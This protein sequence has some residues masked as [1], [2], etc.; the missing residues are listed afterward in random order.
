VDDYPPRP[1]DDLWPDGSERLP[2]PDWKRFRVIWETRLPNLRIRNSCED[3]CPECFILK[4]KFKYLGSRRRGDNEQD[5]PPVGTTEPPVDTTFINDDEQL[6]FNA[7]QH[8]EQAKQQRDIAYQ[9][10]QE[11]FDE[12][13]NEHKEQRFVVI[14][15]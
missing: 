15:L 3:T 4:N 8:A 13:T 10:Q 9:R 5:E 11:A 14:V 6:L 7:N 2:V 12:A 1:Y